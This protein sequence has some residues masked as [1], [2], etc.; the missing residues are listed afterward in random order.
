MDPG[1]ENTG[2]RDFRIGLNL[3][4]RN[5]LGVLGVSKEERVSLAN[6]SPKEGIESID[7]V[8]VEREQPMLH[9]LTLSSSV[10]IMS[11]GGDKR[12]SSG[13]L[14]KVQLSSFSEFCWLSIISATVIVFSTRRRLRCSCRGR[15]ISVTANK[16]ANDGERA[17]GEMT[18]RRRRC[19]EWRFW[20]CS[21][22]GLLLVGI[23]T[24]LV[25]VVGLVV[26]LVV[27][28]GGLKERHLASC[29]SLRFP[30]VASDIGR[31]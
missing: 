15:G 10:M 28:V 31:T 20:G 24:G 11:S 5:G 13:L 22:P 17:S 26:K 2:S 12:T 29:R 4:P 9:S 6:E 3:R 27:V 19:E 30:I 16:A 25:G 14:L 8:L 1:G 7:I 21:K 23:L 18:S